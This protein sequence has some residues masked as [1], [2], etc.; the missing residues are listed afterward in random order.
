[1]FLCSTRSSGVTIFFFVQD[2]Y[3]V[4]AQRNEEDEAF[5]AVCGDGFSVEPN[6]IIFCDRCDIAVHQRCYDIHDVPQDEWLCWPCKEFEDTQ[7]AAGQCQDDIR[8]LH[9]LP[10]QRRKLPGGS[11]EVH[12][13]LCPIRFG[14]FRKTVDGSAWVHQTC[15]LWHPET[16]LVSGTGPNI[17]D[18]VWSIPDIR[19]KTEC[20]L[21][22]KTEGAVVACGHSSC[23]YSFHVMCAR[24]CGLYLS[25]WDEIFTSIICFELKV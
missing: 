20:D 19:F 11:R 8:P 12:C 25:T 5:C 16:F 4:L 21:C 18:G 6:V 23:P 10:E 17:I 9:M 14:A 1:M 15:A 2:L 22:G 3:D 13:C 7:R 24:N